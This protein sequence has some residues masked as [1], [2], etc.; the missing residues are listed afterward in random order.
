[1]LSKERPLWFRLSS[2]GQ[3]ISKTVTL[4]ARKEPKE[5]ITGIRKLKLHNL[6]GNIGPQ[7]GD[8]ARSRYGLID[9]D[10]DTNVGERDAGLGRGWERLHLIGVSAGSL[11]KRR[12]SKYNTVIGSHA[13]NT[14]MIPLENAASWVVKQPCQFIYS[15]SIE[16]Q[17]TLT[18][19]DKNNNHRIEVVPAILCQTLAYTSA[20]PDVWIT[21]EQKHIDERVLK[22]DSS[23]KVEYEKG[24]SE[25]NMM[26]KANYSETVSKIKLIEQQIRNSE[27]MKKWNIVR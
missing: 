5:I 27:K 16:S 13:M 8:M 22:M 11:H 1:M 4:Q 6:N 26:N 10:L 21:I 14:A 19:I 3:V 7:T 2:S 12:Y 25:E 20:D 18:F 15:V 23:L 9:G 17:K 24:I